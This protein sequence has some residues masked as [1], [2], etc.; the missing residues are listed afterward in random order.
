[1]KFWIALAAL[2]ISQLAGIA[3][4]Q[5][6]ESKI[7]TWM[8]QLKPLPKVHYSWPLAIVEKD[9]AKQTERNKL[10]YEYVP[11]SYTHLTLPTTPYV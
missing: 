6:P 1:M 7:L 8:K 2:L 3:D 11:V 10:L 4:G 5:V 9:R